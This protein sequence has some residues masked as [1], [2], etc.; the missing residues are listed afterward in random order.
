MNR[1][2]ELSVDLQQAVDRLINT[3]ASVRSD[4]SC[5]WGD[6]RHAAMIN[7]LRHQIW[8][9]VDDRARAV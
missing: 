9:A 2:D 7:E 6:V 5:V 3:M 4:E 8:S 1:Y